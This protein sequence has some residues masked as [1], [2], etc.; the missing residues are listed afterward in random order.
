MTDDEMLPRPR[1]RRRHA[2]LALACATTACSVALHPA[3]APTRPAAAPAATRTVLAPATV[4]PT[5]SASPIPRLT[6]LELPPDAATDEESTTPATAD[7]SA[8]V[9][10]R[11]GT[12]ALERRGDLLVAPARRDG[13]AIGDLLLDTGTGATFFDQALADELRLPALITASTE[14]THDEASIR[15]LRGLTVGDLALAT[16]RTFVVDLTDA[17]ALVGGRLAGVIGFPALG[18][19]P[20][21][22]DF[23]TATL[24]L[25]ADASFEPPANVPDEA[26]RIDQGL[27]FVEATLADGTTVWLLFDTGSSAA[28]TVWRGFAKQHPGIVR[29]AATAAGDAAPNAAAESELRALRLL[30]EQHERIPV[31]LQDAPARPWQRARVVGRV[32]MALLRD[33]RITVHPATER[34]WVERPLRAGSRE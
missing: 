21:T 9:A 13:R 28:L 11:A 7:T 14:G 5:P 17:D 16:E 23:T 29:R 4:T 2:V 24:T 20:F 25:H 15:E 31:L 18:S 22:L 19:A 30:G 26:L 8:S 27:P 34:I 1:L 32:G 10:A 33:L 12:V 3:G 6:H